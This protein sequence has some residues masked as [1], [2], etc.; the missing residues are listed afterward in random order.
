M[1]ASPSAISVGIVE[2]RPLLDLEYREDVSLLPAGSAGAQT[3]AA[4]RAKV[5]AA[6]AAWRSPAPG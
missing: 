2:G 6:N 4:P 3:A 5:D 1:A